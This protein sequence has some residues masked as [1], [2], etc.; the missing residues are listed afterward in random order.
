MIFGFR[1]TSSGYASLKIFG[2]SIILADPSSPKQKKS[3]KKSPVKKTKKK[4][5]KIV[6]LFLQKGF[7]KK[8]MQ[9]ILS[10]INR[11]RKL[12]SVKIKR[13]WIRYG[14]DDPAKT[15]QIFGIA[16]SAESIVGDVFEF[17]PSF[18][19]K[20]LKWEIDLQIKVRILKSFV[21]LFWM[22]LSFPWISALKAWMQVRKSEGIVLRGIV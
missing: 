15:G 2:K 14:S 19:E 16:T 1:T 21:V 17:E 6:A 7:R 22:F 8:I 5:K 18:S 13:I 20:E 9:W 12:S 4:S 11:L 10:Q 3:S